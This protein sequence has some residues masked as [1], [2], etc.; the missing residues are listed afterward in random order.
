MLR[1]PFQPVVEALCV[2]GYMN[3]FGHSAHTGDDADVDLGYAGGL[4]FREV[5]ADL[6]KRWGF[7]GQGSVGA[8][9]WCGYREVFGSLLSV[10]YGGVASR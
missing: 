7:E 3:G 2:E 9:G 1:V 10:H 5:G 8:G 6:G 4:W